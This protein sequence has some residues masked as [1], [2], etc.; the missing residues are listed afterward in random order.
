VPKDNALPWSGKEPLNS[1]DRLTVPVAFMRIAILKLS[2][3]LEDSFRLTTLNEINRPFTT[4]QLI[5]RYPTVVGSSTCA[6]SL[7]LSTPQWETYQVR[8]ESNL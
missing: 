7:P 6:R 2:D 3:D 5:V 8:N 1:V 4:E